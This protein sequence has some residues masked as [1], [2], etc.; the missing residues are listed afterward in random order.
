MKTFNHCTKCNSAH[1]WREVDYNNVLYISRENA[2]CITLCTNCINEFANKPP[3]IST[4]L[5]YQQRIDDVLSSHVIVDD[6][7]NSHH[8]KASSESL[9][10]A[11][12][13]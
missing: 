11:L 6:E 1:N 5:G 2:I 13:F 10:W 8:Q 7:Q 3:K 9:L 4:I 12:S